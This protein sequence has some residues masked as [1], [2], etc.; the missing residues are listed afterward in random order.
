MNY[1]SKIINVLLSP[2]ALLYGA[3]TTVRNKLYDWGIIKS[4]SPTP[5]CIVVGNLNTGG[6][7][8]SPMVEYLIELLL[9]HHKQVTA[10]SR[11]YGRVTKGFREVQLTDTATNVGDEPLQFKHLFNKQCTVIVDEKRAHA[12]QQLQST[13]TKA[14][15]YVLDDALQH[16]SVKGSTNILLT[17]YNDLFVNDAMLPVGNLRENKNGYERAN[18]IVVTKCPANITAIDKNIISKR[19]QLLPHQSIFFSS[20]LYANLVSVTDANNTIELTKTTAIISFSGIANDTPFV[21]YLQEKA[22]LLQHISFADHH[23]FTTIDIDKI[24]TIIAQNNIHNPVIITTHKDGMRLLQLQADFI[25]K[26]QLY[27]LPTKMY[28]SPN[29][30]QQFN[31][32]ILQQC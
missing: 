14:T 12:L 30:Q 24:I 26:I 19:I 28:F 23:N 3:I 9:T 21:N 22:N 13:E 15:V 20:I 17:A 6:T 16:R 2:I 1:H 5:P 7:G 29:E 18:I 27:Y 31:K 32:L 4:Y 25:T 10:I 8:K 11:G